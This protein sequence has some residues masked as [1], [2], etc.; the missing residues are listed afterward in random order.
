MAPIVAANTAM[1]GSTTWLSK[2]RRGGRFL[3]IIQN[4][5]TNPAGKLNTN[6][7]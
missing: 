7:S 4:S 3:L 1:I 5:K 6:P 2:V